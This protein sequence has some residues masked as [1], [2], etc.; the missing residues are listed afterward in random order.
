[1]ELLLDLLEGAAWVGFVLALGFALGRIID[2]KWP[3]G[4]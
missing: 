3:L 2:R 4:S 1:M